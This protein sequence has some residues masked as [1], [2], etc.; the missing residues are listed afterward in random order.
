MGALLFVLALIVGHQTAALMF[1]LQPGQQKCFT[2]EFAYDVLVS[3]D[4]RVASPGQDAK[5]LKLT[6]RRAAAAAA[7]NARAFR[8]ADRP[9]SSASN[10][11]AA[12][13]RAPAGSRR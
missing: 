11:R 12:R 2:D 8:R 7:A 1:Y 10:R 13:R 5:S 9:Q 6:V 3:G 4:Y